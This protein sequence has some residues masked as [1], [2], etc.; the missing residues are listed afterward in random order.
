MCRGRHTAGMYRPGNMGMKSFMGLPKTHCAGDSLVSGSGVLR[1]CRIARWNSSVSRL[2]S[3]VVLLVMR[4]FIV[5]TAISALQLEWGKAMED[6]QWCIP[7]SRRNWRVAEDVNSGPPS[8][9][10]S[11]GIPK[12]VKMCQRL[13]ISPFEPSCAHSIIGQFD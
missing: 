5:L 10:H 8:V 11:S 13:L 1:Y 6:R 2:P 12:V 3:G 4:R 9:A 7:Q